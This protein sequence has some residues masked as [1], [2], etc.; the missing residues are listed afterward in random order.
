MTTPDIH[1][2]FISSSNKLKP[3]E[4]VDKKP[5][6]KLENTLSE[7]PNTDEKRVNPDYK[8]H[9]KDGVFY[10]SR[11]L[12]SNSD[13]VLWNSEFTNN[14]KKDDLADCFLQGIWYLK[15]NNIISF[16]DDLKINIV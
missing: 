15:H 9:K 10:C 14:K 7:T 8:Q 2:D 6:Q 3:F 11:I 16:A 4:T 12:N 5:K 13:L 1:I